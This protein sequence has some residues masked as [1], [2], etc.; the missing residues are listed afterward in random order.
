ML[1]HEGRWRTVE[2]RIRPGAGNKVIGRIAGVD[3]R[4]AAEALIGARFSVPR[5]ELP[6]LEDGEYY[7]DEVVG[8]DVYEG[9]THVGHVVAVHSTGPVE[10]IEL[11]GE[12][13]L[14]S[15]ADR[16]LAIDRDARRIVIAEGSLAV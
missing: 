16:L 6:P 10:V 4:N 12:R 15:T 3:D 5:S 2:L 11:D 9:D 13:Y 14:P 8:M 7:L 1:E